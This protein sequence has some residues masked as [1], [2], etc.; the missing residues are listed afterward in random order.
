VIRFAPELREFS[1]QTEGNM[2]QMEFLRGAVENIAVIN[3][4]PFPAFQH[5]FHFS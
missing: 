5:P 2:N 4:R 3:A 1:F